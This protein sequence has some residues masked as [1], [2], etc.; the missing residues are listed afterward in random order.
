MAKRAE[1]RARTSRGIAVPEGGAVVR[2]YCTGLGDCFLI[3]LRDSDG[4]PGYILIDCGVW[5]GTPGASEWMNRIMADIKETV[6]ARGLDLVIATHP[7]W[8]HLSGFGQAKAVF[9]TIPVKEVWLPWTEDDTD[10]VAVRLAAERRLAIRA[11]VSAAARLEGVADRA[12]GEGRADEANR[13]A[14]A[15]ANIDALL[16]FIG[17][18]SADDPE[19]D[20]ALLEAVRRRRERIGATAGEGLALGELGAGPTTDDLLGFVRDRVSQPRY[21]KPS[22]RPLA[23]V[24]FPGVRIYALGPPTDPKLLGK[25]NP[26]SGPGK[27]E[28]YL[29]VGGVPLNEDSALLAAALPAGGDDGDPTLAAWRDRFRPFDRVAGIDADRAATH[30]DYGPFFRRMYGFGPSDPAPDWR[31]ID[32]DWLEAAGQLALNLDDHVNNTS[33]ALAIELGEGEDA[34]VLLFPGDAQVGNWLSWH[35]LGGD[36][37]LARSLLRRTVLYKVG[38][39]ASHNATL[40]ALGLKLMTDTDRLVAMIPV[41]QVEAHKPKGGNKDGWDMP[42]GKLLDDLTARTEGRVFR[43]DLGVPLLEGTK[44]DGWPKAKWDAFVKDTHVETG[45]ITIQGKKVTRPFSIQYTVRSR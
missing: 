38:H 10:P 30:P 41:D 16:R 40:K 13:A 34:P 20:K 33:L 1:G 6:G 43:S 24:P 22:P 12:A 2:M 39:H 45:T 35:Q 42:Y 23:G 26:S 3:A 25:D 8:D 36:G 14:T 31:R 7:H 21:L 19:E 4:E 9:D 28:V 29:G 17:P 5:K 32:T 18:A 11:A 27:S 15:A 37:T 44:P